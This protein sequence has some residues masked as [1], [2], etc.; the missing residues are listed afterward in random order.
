MEVLQTALNESFSC[1]C[2]KEHKI[3]IKDISFTSDLESLQKMC[4]QFLNGEKL[5][6]VAD[7]NTSEVLGEKVVRYLKEN[8]YDVNVYVYSE[9]R[10]KPDERALGQLIMNIPAQTAGIIVVGSGTLNDLVR[11]AAT[12]VNSP[13][14]SV[15]TAPSMD[16]YASSVSS[17]IMDNNKTTFQGKNAEAVFCDLQVITDAPLELIKAGFGDIIGKRIAMS[18]WMLS[19]II[20]GEYFCDYAAELVENSAD[21]C[22][23][24]A[25]RIF[26]RDRKGIMS[27]MEA[28][29]L[30]GIAISAA[31]SSRPASG[32]EH[33][34]AHYIEG[35]FLKQ[36]RKPL[37]HGT[38]VAFSTLCA[39]RFYEYIL[40]HDEFRQFRMTD[41]ERR[42]LVKAVPAPADVE[43]W[44]SASGFSTNP[45]DYNI[46]KALLEE[47]LLKAR[48]TR[49]RYTVLSF[50]DELGVLKQG[51][52]YVLEQLYAD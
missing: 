34:L 28:L 41:E 48:F 12:R 5:F 13:F 38:A 23:N 43:K 47:A 15:P 24:N 29:L 46:E 51:T 6:V 22:I 2:G 18:D 8:K 44:L 9:P 26:S 42:R 21:L 33:L 50:A 1:T 11:L 16:G 19:V 40:N 36:G 39:S 45:S 52:R 25:A 35:A 10:L 37:Y 27:L 49:D 31:G 14:I 3:S 17:L 32:T 30:S 7:E 4:R 20:N